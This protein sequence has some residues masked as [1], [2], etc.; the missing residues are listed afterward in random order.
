MAS[1]EQQPAQRPEVPETIRRLIDGSLDAAVLLDPNLRPLYWNT[2]YQK[3]SGLRPRQLEQTT[4]EG[5]YCF[6]LFPIEV[7]ETMCLAKRVFATNRS[8]RVDEIRARR[9]D[10][11]E[12]VLIVTATPINDAMVLETYRDVTADARI[13]RKYKLLLERERGAKDVLEKKVMER[14]VALENA[15][16]ELKVTQAQLIHQEKMSS[17][18]RLVA[19]IAHELNNPI[20]FVYGNVEFLG[21]YFRDLIDLVELIEGGPLPEELR[22][23]IDAKKQEIE[24][25]FLR[26]DSDKLLHS[27]RAGAERTAAIVRD[28]KTFSRTGSGKIAETNLQQGIETTLNL[29]APLTKNRVRV[30]SRYAPEALRVYCHAGHINQ[31]FMN[32]LTNA[33][34]SIRGEGE[35]FVSVEPGEPGWVRIKVSDTGPGIQ[36]HILRQIF[37]PFFTTKDVG[38]GTGLGLTI[39]EGIVRAHGGRIYVQDQ[40]DPVPAWAGVQPTQSPP[41]TLGA[42]FV[43]ELPVR[44]PI[45]Q[46]RSEAH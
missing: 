34:Q 6:Q 10:G 16:E 21:R 3:Y 25:E 33:A 5:R 28:L 17:L 14:T 43:I 26:T 23:R 35:I 8:V 39:S 11:E 9:G 19:G 42:T 46:D 18:G 24:Y 30:H 40:P 36:P 1:P 13:Q 31:V 15:N 44:P 45:R 20:N 27:I 29:I 41:R 7:C 12:I 37:D 22:K 38:E 32:V 4:D 2:A